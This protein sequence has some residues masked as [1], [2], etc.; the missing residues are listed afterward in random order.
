MKLLNV[1]CV[2]VIV[3]VADA[4]IETVRD[5]HGLG[6][7]NTRVSVWTRDKTPFDHNRVCFL[8]TTVS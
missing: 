4:R 2:C 8:T 5:K 1:V 3:R 6:M 7:L